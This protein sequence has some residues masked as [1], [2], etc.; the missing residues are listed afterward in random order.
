MARRLPLVLFLAALLV[1]CWAF[2][3]PAVD[4]QAHRKKNINVYIQLGWFTKVEVVE[5]YP[6]VWV[7]PAFLAFPHKDQ[8]ALVAVVYHYYYDMNNQYDQVIVRNAV[9][10]QK[11]GVFS[12]AVGGL[13]MGP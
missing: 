13:R 10:D 7:T 1:A 8:Q 12:K 11:S 5:G 4:T 2:P 6:A 9:S 3:A